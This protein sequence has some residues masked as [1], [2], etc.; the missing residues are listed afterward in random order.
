MLAR[1]IFLCA[2]A[3]LWMPAAS[4]ADSSSGATLR[5]YGSGRVL[6]NG[7]PAPVSSTLFPND[8]LE[9]GAGS[10]A[11]ISR[12]GW[13][14]T[15]TSDSVARFEG[16]AVALEKG[17]VEVVVDFD[18]I[19]LP[20]IRIRVGCYTVRAVSSE[21]TAYAVIET[22]GNVVVDA[23]INDVYVQFR[24]HVTKKGSPAKESDRYIIQRDHR[25][26]L[27]KKCGGTAK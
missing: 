3:I 26:N 10:E 5:T 15:V 17:T 7:K 23:Q 19:S 6:L 20:Q 2:W 9:A 21:R 27:P 24:D 4:I 8:K 18:D 12:D 25:E 11:H 22:D 13:V 14:V 16:D 1:W